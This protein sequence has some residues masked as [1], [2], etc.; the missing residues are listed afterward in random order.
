MILS[1]PS[2]IPLTIDVISEGKTTLAIMF[3]DLTAQTSHNFKPLQPSELRLYKA[4]V[5]LNIP[6]FSDSIPVL[7][8]ENLNAVPLHPKHN[9]SFC[10]SP[11]SSVLSNPLFS[12]NHHNFGHLNLVLY[13]LGKSGR[14]LSPIV[15]TQTFQI[16]E[17]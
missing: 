17:F 14:V 1:I 15:M 5:H 11:K 8:S 10:S 4:I 2:S 6:T 16:Q 3:S 9:H 13:R 7:E 12:T